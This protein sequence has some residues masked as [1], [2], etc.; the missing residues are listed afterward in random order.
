M[1]YQ[2][3]L[4]DYENKKQIIDMNKRLILNSNNLVHEFSKTLERHDIELYS[5]L[6]YTIISELL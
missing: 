6:L 5:K 3:F 1:N 4:S 2:A